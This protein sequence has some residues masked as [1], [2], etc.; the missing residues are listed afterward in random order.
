MKSITVRTVVLLVV[1]F[2][3][4]SPT[5]NMVGNVL[6]FGIARGVGII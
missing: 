4:L 1:G 2:V 5:L 6:A 3:V